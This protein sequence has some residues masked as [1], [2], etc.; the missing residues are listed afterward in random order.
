[1]IPKHLTSVH[2]KYNVRYF[3][4]DFCEPAPKGAPLIQGYSNVNIL[5][6]EEKSKYFRKKN[7]A[8]LIKS[9]A[10]QQQRIVFDREEDVTRRKIVC[11]L[12][13]L[14]I[15]VNLYYILLA[16]THTA[17]NVLVLWLIE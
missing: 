11:F 14:V 9:K 3:T 2:F 10:E 1:M 7:S 5:I 16:K 8:I 13:I 4:D 17:V 15:F 12:C 6:F